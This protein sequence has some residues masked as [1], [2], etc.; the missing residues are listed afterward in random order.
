MNNY[1]IINME[2]LKNENKKWKSKLR[3]EN[4]KWEWEMRM[5]NKNEK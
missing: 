4:E 3:I 1:R 5:E 2:L